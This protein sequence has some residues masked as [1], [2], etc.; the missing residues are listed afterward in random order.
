MTEA[1][2]QQDMLPKRK[3]LFVGWDAADWKVMTPLMEQGRM[4]N[5]SRLVERGVMGNLA[6]LQPVLSPMLW[7]SIA[8]GKRP[9]KHGILGFTEPTPDGGA[10]QP[11]SQLSRTT[12][13]IWNMLNQ[14][15]HKSGVVGWWPSHPVEAINGVMVSNH[16]HHAVGPPDQPWPLPPGS[17]HPENMAEILAELR[18]NPN[19]L[20]PEEVLPFIPKAAEI[21]QSKDRRLGSMMK[22][23]AECISMNNAATWLLQNESWDFFAVYFDAIDHF[24]HGFMKYHPPRREWIAERDFELYSGVV[25]AGYEFHDMMLGTLLSLV[26][27]DT[28][29]V[30]CSDHG[31]HPDHLRPRQIPREP[32]GPAVEHRDLG[33]FVMA[34]PGIKKD[35]LIHGANVL[36]ITPTLLVLYGLPVGEDMDGK[37]LLQA[38]ETPP[39][40]KRIPSWDAVPGDDGRHSEALR[41]DP[42]AAKA[43]LDQ[44]VAL[45]YVEAPGDNAAQAVTRTAREMR[46]NLA[47]SYMNA[48]LYPQAIPIL[49]ELHEAEP[50]ETRFGT[51]LAMS[52]RAIGETPALRELVERLRE[53]RVTLAARAGEHIEILRKTLQ[54]RREARKA[55]REAAEQDNSTTDQTQRE[56]LLSRQERDDW[57][58]WREQKGTTNYDLDF[59]MSCVL[60]DEGKPEE[61]MEYLAKA[62]EAQPNRPGLHIQVGET[63]LKMRQPKAAEEA[64]GKALAID[65]LNFHAHLGLA[66]ACHRQRRHEEAAR[67]ALE[68][69][70]LMFHYPMAHFVLGRALFRLRRFEAAARSLEIATSLNPNFKQ[71]HRMLLWVYR[72]WVNDP[73]AAR[74][75]RSSLEKLRRL[76]RQRI[77][78]NLAAMRDEFAEA[79]AGEREALEVPLEKTAPTILSK[80][81]Y[82]DR[83]PDE[84]APSEYV[85]VV[86]G[87]PRSGTSM[88]MQMLDAGGLD[89]LT[90]RKRKAD[91]D[92]PKGYYELEKATQLRK[93]R[94]W[95]GNAMSKGVKIVAQLLP[96]LPKDLPIRVVFIERNL[97]EVLASQKTMLSRMKRDSGKF[98]DAQIQAAYSRQL[99]MVKQWLANNPNAWVLYLQHRDV[100]REPARCAGLVN[101]F[102]GGRLD[103]EA[104]AQVVDPELYRQRIAQ[105]V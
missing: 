4:P 42:L 63:Y 24:S 15:G 67:E 68:T 6:T 88:M 73:E 18:F 44:L 30:M 85:T 53:T 100:I 75:H 57:R 89:I 102:L 70:R 49:Q 60:L 77:D 39:E 11:V 37:P 96:F 2:A 26:D 29:V 79:P 93:K 54:E 19:E 83:L 95:L 52:Y 5:L 46:Y 23:L 51:Q 43:A 62:G 3:T 90:D 50:E 91:E 48:D 104:M 31:F 8:T 86:A 56:P 65:P 27:D 25:N 98:S 103:V 45:G 84:S 74:R 47:R 17:V 80:P 32:A 1:A 101:H 105:P 99:D 71:A 34:G 33:M 92:N 28:T 9:F 97:D 10:V 82:R 7:T 61:A 64:F 21:D 35:E 41:Q 58:R 81:E 76:K 87:L 94:D 66:R 14:T 12:K 59:L 36:D 78:D 22:I 20:V 69:V 40:V 72:Y 16:Y 38:F 55:E 13:A